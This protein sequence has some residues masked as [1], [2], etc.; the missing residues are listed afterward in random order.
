MRLSLKYLIG[1]VALLSVV[2]TLAASIISGFRAEQQSLITSTLETNH[3]YAVKMAQS[4]EAF[5][6]FY[7]SIPE[8]KRKA[9]CP[10]YRV[11]NMLMNYLF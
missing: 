7:A 3:A 8:S 6:T 1:L 9:C 4:T 10:L 2:L 11:G 5:F